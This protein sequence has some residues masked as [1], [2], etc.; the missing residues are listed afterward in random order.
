[1][2]SSPS[3]VA[4]IAETC[5]AEGLTVQNGEKIATALAAEFNVHPD[6]VGILRLE[7]ESLVFVYPAK[8]HNVGRI[9]LN[10]SSSVAVRTLNTK[11]PEIM[12]NFT[13]TKH[14]SFFEMVDIGGKKDGP[15]M[16]R[17]HGTI[18]KLMTVPVL[19]A[20]KVAG[21]IQVSRKGPTLVGAGPDFASADLQRLV[22]MAGTLAKCF[23]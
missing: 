9:P 14:S 13:K 22:G 16:G 17:E 3:P 6:E 19:V 20:G 2:S 15:K 1:M 10:N 11:R 4:Q 5:A 7:G 8:L 18:Q 21:V 23:K 12:N